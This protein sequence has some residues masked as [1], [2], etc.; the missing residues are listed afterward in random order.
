MGS[1]VRKENRAEHG[2]VAHLAR[3]DTV[4][5]NQHIG[6]L[7]GYAVSHNERNGCLQGCYATCPHIER[8]CKPLHLQRSVRHKYQLI[9]QIGV[10]GGHQPGRQCRLPCAHF[11]WQQPAVSSV[12]QTCSMKQQPPLAA[13][14]QVMAQVSQNLL[15]G[16]LAKRLE[17]GCARS[18]K[19]LYR[20]VLLRNKAYGPAAAPVRSPFVGSCVGQQPLNEPIGMGSLEF[21]GDG[22]PTKCDGLCVHS[23]C[24]RGYGCSLSGPSR[25]VA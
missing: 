16:C 6:I 8:A 22:A 13:S 19:Q 21:Q 2:L 23:V 7:G 10:M 25:L 5:R 1:I 11:T 4:G 15:V 3:S 17:G 14:S 18:R 24:Q 12:T 20:P 9:T